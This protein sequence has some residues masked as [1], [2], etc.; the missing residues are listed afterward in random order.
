[1]NIDVQHEVNTAL[2]DDL[3]TGVREHN[4]LRL[5]EEK[6]IPLSVS[7]KDSKGKVIA[8]VSGR[9]IYKQFLVEVLWADEA[10][11]GKGLGRRIMEQAELEARKRGCV[12]AQVDTLSIQAPEFYQKLGFDIIGKVPGMT[13][14]HDRY[15]LMKSYI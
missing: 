8:G 11:R 14:D 15:F 13:K 12:T 4:L 5:G 2:F 1:M 6:A 10:V 9:T 7:V 3:V